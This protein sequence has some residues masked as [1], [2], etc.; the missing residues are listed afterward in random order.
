MD[1]VGYDKLGSNPKKLLE[2]VF[3][4]FLVQFKVENNIL[5]IDHNQNKGKLSNPRWPPVD[6][7]GEWS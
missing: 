6:E 1:I 3:Q 5:K 2:Q 7:P 4:L